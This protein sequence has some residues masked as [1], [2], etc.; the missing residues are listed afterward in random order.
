MRTQALLIITTLFFGPRLL[1]QEVLWEEK[2]SS[3]Q[4][5]PLAVDDKPSS[6]EKSKVPRSKP[7]TGALPGYYAGRISSN[8]SVNSGHLLGRRDISNELRSLK[9]GSHTG[10]QITHRVLG[11]SSKQLT[12]SATLLGS[13]CR[14]CYLVG[15]ASLDA[16]AERVFIK[17]DRFVDS[18]GASTAIVAEFFSSVGEEGIQVEI[19]SNKTGLFTGNLLS[20]FVAAYFD[21]LIQRT[22]GP[23]GTVTEQATVD[24]ALKKGLAAGAISSAEQ[25]K[26]E[27]SKDS[28]FGL[29]PMMP[30]G[31]V[32]ITEISS[33]Q[34]I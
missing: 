14:S 20:S 16:R 19:E 27:L 24:T 12:V 26:S 9:I 18:L 10:V 28:A 32:I 11:L 22:N 29:G 33:K 30:T 31:S 15:K 5:A 34:S 3:H 21:G 6:R 2:E 17:F 7:K 13:S 4:R 8:G 1:S 25:F 23:F